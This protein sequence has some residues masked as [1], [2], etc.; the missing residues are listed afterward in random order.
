[1]VSPGAA[2]SGLTT[3]SEPCVPRELKLESVS[4][5]AGVTSWMVAC[6]EPSKVTFSVPAS[7]AGRSL[8]VPTLGSWNTGIDGASR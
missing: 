6:S 4:S 3:P 8:S 1:M 2:T 5:I 7:T